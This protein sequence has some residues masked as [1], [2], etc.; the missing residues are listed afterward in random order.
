MFAALFIPQLYAEELHEEICC[1]PFPSSMIQIGGNYTHLHLKPESTPSISLNMGGAQAMYEYR[2][3]N[4]FYAAVKGMFRQGSGS[5]AISRRTLID[6]D[7]QERLGYTFV[8]CV[9]NYFFTLFTGFGYRYLSHKLTEHQDT[10]HLNYSEFYVPVGVLSDFVITSYF[11]IG[12]NAIWMPQVD[13]TVELV[14]IGGA[15]WVL[16]RK[17]ANVLVELPFTFL[18]GCQDEFA[19]IVKPFYEHWQDGRSTAVS[20]VGIP[21]GLVGNTYNFWGVELNLGYKF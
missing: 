20:S 14:P 19:L 5:N 9:R 11:M 17:L 6:I 2:P 7:A 1:N 4:S 3:D 12:L 21:L 18:W 8:D 16:H 13:P 10:L 15:R